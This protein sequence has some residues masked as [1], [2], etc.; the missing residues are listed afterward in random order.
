[1]KSKGFMAVKFRLEG[2]AAV[3]A[4]FWHLLTTWIANDIHR[5]SHDV[6][7]GRRHL[8]TQYCSST[9]SPLLTWLIKIIAIINLYP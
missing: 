5:K 2:V 3:P 8:Y 1:M 4:G 9:L 6:L 7:S